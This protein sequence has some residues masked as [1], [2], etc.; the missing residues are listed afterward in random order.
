MKVKPTFRLRHRLVCHAENGLRSVPIEKTI[1]D[2]ERFFLQSP[3]EI[4]FTFIKRG[5]RG[6][7]R[8]VLKYHSPEGKSED[9][10]FF[11]KG[12]TIGQNMASACFEFFER[13]CARMRPDDRLLEASYREVAHQ[14]ADP[15]LFDLGKTTFTPD[16]KIE[17]I[18]AYSLTRRR[19]LLVPA[20]LVFLP[21]QADKLDKHIVMSDSNG[22]ASG[23]NMEEAILHALLEVIERDLVNIT[24]YNRFPYRR[25]DPATVPE[26][27]HPLLK[28]LEKKGFRVY[29]LSGYTDL[30]IPF[31]T[32]FL[33]HRKI[34]SRCAVS[35]GAYPDP[36]I[37]LERAI[38]EAVQMLPPSA[39]HKE[40]IQSGA[41][42][43]FRTEFPEVIPFASI[44]NIATHDILETI[45][46]CV[47]ALEEIGSEVFAVDLSRPD[48][49]FPAVRVLA[50]HLQ[51]RL[52]EDSLRLSERFF[53]VPVKLGFFEQQR[54][55][56][57][58]RLWPICGYR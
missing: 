1:R 48:I 20:N 10:H 35:Y 28:I 16:L 47:A 42:Q 43:F 17:W 49:P 7:N 3:L 44:R 51:P 27:C 12:L 19:H 2:M 56:A 9:K 34:S 52:N 46:I 58:V 40:W 36:V 50:T 38:T 32:V 53:E 22:I 45:E 33:Q 8:A 6:I 11:G 37:A 55:M 39:N 23:N 29:L 14:A 24:E 13:Y 25:I 21:Y 31:I 15:R 5:L 41:P 18:W 4:Q 57:D 54:T 26:V 30:P